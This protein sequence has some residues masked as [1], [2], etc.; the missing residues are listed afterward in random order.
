M[1]LKKFQ[2]YLFFLFGAF[3]ASAI[4]GYVWWAKY[5]LLPNQVEDLKN[6]VELISIQ[7]DTA[8]SRML[9]LDK[10]EFKIDQV[11][12]GIRNDYD[13]LQKFG[14]P[15]TIVALVAI[16]FSIYK[17][18]L[19]FALQNAKEV[20]NQAYLSDEDVFKAEKRILVLTK[21]GGDTQFIRQF[22]WQTGLL[23]A[24]T[25]PKENTESLTEKVLQK[26]FKDDTYD[27]IF[28]NNEKVAFE[29]TEIKLCFS[30][31]PENTMLFNFGNK[32]LP[33]DLTAFQNV[34]SAKFK[35]QIYGNLINAF[36]Y[37]KCMRRPLGN[38]KP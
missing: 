10:L 36:K 23:Q 37:Q 20:I 5:G 13:W 18:A 33:D 30:L 4:C 26:L 38:G 24:A 3:L 9:T 1:S 19:G 2:P 21:K 25:I 34:T 27:L 32:N 28:L 14:L 6:K 8:K 22:L 17:A 35:S 31:M 15:L 11:E 16:F 29:D 7:S 12:K